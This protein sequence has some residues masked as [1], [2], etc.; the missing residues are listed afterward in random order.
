VRRGLQDSKIRINNTLIFFKKQDYT[1]FVLIA[2]VNLDRG[3]HE[4]AN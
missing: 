3:S 1:D 2:P 4:E